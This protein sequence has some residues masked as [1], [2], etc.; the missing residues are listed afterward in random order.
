MAIAFELVADF[1]SD[2]RFADACLQWLATRISPIQLDQY[3]IAIHPPLANGYPYANPSRFKVSLIPA[4]VG[5]L[6]ALDD[7]VERIPLNDSQLSR[8]G[9]RLYDILRGAPHFELAMVG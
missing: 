4:N 9:N 6:V 8:L 3:C 5:S 2:K 7:T 1:G